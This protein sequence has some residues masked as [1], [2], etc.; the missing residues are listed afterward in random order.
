MAFP[1]GYITMIGERGIRLSGCE[2]QRMAIA[3]TILKNPKVIL[4]D[5]ASIA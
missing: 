5:E 2:K 3:R 1:D 4:L